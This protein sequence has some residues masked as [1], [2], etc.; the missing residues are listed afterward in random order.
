MA[1][2]SSKTNPRKSVQSVRRPAERRGRR[3]QKSHIKRV[4][5]AVVGLGHIAQVAVLPAFKNAK[6]SQIVALVTGDKTKAKKLGQKYKADTYGYDEYHT[7]LESGEIDAVYIALPN[8]L[9]REFAQVA[10]EKG[11][12]VLC[13]K[14][15]CTTED[16]CIELHRASVFHQRYLMTA[17]RLHFEE[18]NLKALQLIQSGKIGAPK[19]FTSQFS[20]QIKDKNNIRLRRDVGGGS[21]W[22]IGIYCINAARSLFQA[23][24][25]RVY[26]QSTQPSTDDRF[27]ETE[28]SMS[29]MMVFP[30]NRTAVFT[31]S[32]DADTTS[33]Y[34]VVGEK[35]S[36]HLE[37][38]YEYA[39]ARKLEMRKDNQTKQ[40]FRFKKADQF[41]AEIKYF[42]DCILKAQS[43]EPDAIEGMMDVQI[44]RAIYE[45]SEQNRP[46]DLDYAAPEALVHHP[47]PG[48]AQHLPGH[49]EPKLV[50]V[51]SPS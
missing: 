35:G 18:S 5:Y 46:I 11:I 15:L 26:A 40:T 27:A 50:H 16:D 43:P 23:D 14:P 45:S 38:A 9:H 19:F 32:F 30:E 24:P 39:S 12:H 51:Q 20:Y 41:A 49:G 25:L 44:I 36:L 33:S 22:D 42:S 34:T 37:N 48:M 13:E 4:R 6:N 17:Y 8:N 7:L 47:E 3:P 21:V 29:V 2:N 28:A 31:C 10:L 1:T